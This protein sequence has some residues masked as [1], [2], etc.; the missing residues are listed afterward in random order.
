MHTHHVPNKN[1]S[2]REK[3]EFF[4]LLCNRR[5]FKSLRRNTICNLQNKW[6]WVFNAWIA[7]NECKQFLKW[8]KLNYACN[9]YCTCTF[10]EQDGVNDLHTWFPSGN[11][12]FI[13]RTVPSLVSGSGGTIKRKSAR[14]SS[15]HCSSII[16]SPCMYIH[17]WH[18]AYYF[19]RTRTVVLLCMGVNLCRNLLLCRLLWLFSL[20]YKYFTWAY[21][22]AL[23]CRNHIILTAIFWIE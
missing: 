8:W 5:I 9:K 2:K 18:K 15:F 17:V 4:E 7:P 11:L 21:Q 6:S 13:L 10:T 19:I 22:R 12:N 20:L 3:A 1:T 14:I 23:C 16:S